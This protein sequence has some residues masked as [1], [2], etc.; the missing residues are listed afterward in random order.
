MKDFTLVILVKDRQYNIPIVLDYYRD[1][2]C[3]KIII[4]SSKQ[5]FNFG[6]FDPGIFEYCYL[7][8]NN[9]FD[10]WTKIHEYELITTKY[11]VDVPDDD[12]LIKRTVQKCLE[13]LKE[14][15]DLVL[16]DGEYCDIAFVG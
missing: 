11:M 5:K 12:F 4:D 8:K 13:K 14:D 16:C 6:E 7:G 2:D 10:K 9:Y 1:W 15:N 3:K